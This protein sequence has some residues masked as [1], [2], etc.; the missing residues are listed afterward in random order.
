MARPTPQV[1]VPSCF[2]PQCEFWLLAPLRTVKFPSRKLKRLCTCS[3]P[4]IEG[5][6]CQSVL[7]CLFLSSR[8][9]YEGTRERLFQYHTK[10]NHPKHTTP[11]GGKARSMSPSPAG[12]IC[13]PHCPVTR[14]EGCNDGYTH[15]HAPGPCAGK[16]TSQ[17]PPPCGPNAGVV[18]KKA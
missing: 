13:D 1:H 17:E 4:K 12:Y 8:S 16:A 11:H 7:I 15:G 10:H 9:D 18:C 3:E 14:T 2:W 6:N 5:L